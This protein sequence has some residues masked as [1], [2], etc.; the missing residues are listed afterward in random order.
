MPIVD[1][2]FGDNG[3]VAARDILVTFG[4]TIWVDIGFD[5][6]HDYENKNGVAPK[7]QATKIPALVDTGASESCIDD[8]L[9]V[10]IGLPII[11]RQLVSGVGGETEVNIYLGHIYIPTI[12]Y[13]QWGRFA[14]VLLSKG[15]QK[16]EALIGRSLLKNCLLVYDG[17]NGNVTLA[18]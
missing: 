4:P 14:G 18:I 8:A 3:E 11:D 15:S 12:G 13:T 1:C 16:H 17:F 5:D 7:S 2:G 6:N 10:K 9:A